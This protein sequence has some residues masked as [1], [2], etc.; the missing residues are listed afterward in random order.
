VESVRRRRTDYARG[1]PQLSV[2]KRPAAFFNS[3]KNRKNRQ[4]FA[5]FEELF[6]RTL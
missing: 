3:L 1:R 5:V 2:E 6:F 4:I